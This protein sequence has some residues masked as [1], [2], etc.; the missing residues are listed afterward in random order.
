MALSNKG[1]NDQTGLVRARQLS[2][3]IQSVE[4]INQA[5][6]RLQF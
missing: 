1:L 6:S 4:T 3:A 2:Q 5:R